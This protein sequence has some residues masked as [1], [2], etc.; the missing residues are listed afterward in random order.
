M[1]WS[2]EQRTSRGVCRGVTS[3]AALFVLVMAPLTLMAYA[4]PQ[5][6][7]VSLSP[8][9]VEAFPGSMFSLEVKVDPGPYGIS[10][11]DII[12][13]F[14][15]GIFSVT[16][17]RPG[18]LLGPHVLVGFQQVDENAGTIRYAIARIGPTTAPTPSGAFMSVEFGVS[19][20]AGLGTYRIRL[21]RVG[22]ADEKFEEIPEAQIALRDAEVFAIPEFKLP[23]VPMILAIVFAL[24]LVTLRMSRRALRAFSPKGNPRLSFNEGSPNG[25]EG[26]LRTTGG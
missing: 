25:A 13:A 1:A 21:I 26:N 19:E 16:K 20:N 10:S 24:T 8:P 4:N 7:S 3:S 2:S 23:I 18:D 14:D 9:T 6:V 11:G 15:P 22:L 12:L 5:A 17:V